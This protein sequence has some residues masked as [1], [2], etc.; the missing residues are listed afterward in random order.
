MCSVYK[1]GRREYIIDKNQDIKDFGAGNFLTLLDF[2]GSIDDLNSLDGLVE[3]HQL[4]QLSTS[5]AVWTDSKCAVRLEF[6]SQAHASASHT[7]F[8]KLL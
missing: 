6:T 2:V 1:P 8:T 3:I 7:F 5:T 4:N